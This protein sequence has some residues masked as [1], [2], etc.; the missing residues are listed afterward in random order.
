MMKLE[1]TQT[2]PLTLTDEGTIR[3]TGSRVSLD[4]IIH[5]YRLGAAAE[6]IAFKF[7]GVQLA[8]INSTIA[9]YLTHREAVEDYLR[10]QESKGDALQR[11]LESDEDYQATIRRMRE[12]LLARRREHEPEDGPTA[13]V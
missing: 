4:S 11:Q 13:T 12:R 1:L 8:D 2:V 3:V 9:Y 6:Q 7:Q 5:H 10:Q